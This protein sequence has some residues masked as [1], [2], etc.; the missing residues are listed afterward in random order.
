MWG[1]LPVSAWLSSWNATRGIGWVQ[2]PIAEAGVVAQHNDPVAAAIKPKQSRL[3]NRDIFT[4]R[5][6][7]SRLVKGS[8]PARALAVDD[9][10]LK[11]SPLDGRA[12]RVCSESAT[13][14]M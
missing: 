3:K 14:G 10:S 9:G 11:A 2:I 1:P 6:G 13:P 5:L 12:D 8:V 7:M 4:Q